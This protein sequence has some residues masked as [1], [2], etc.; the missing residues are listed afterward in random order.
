MT[1]LDKMK[2]ES[3]RIS[4]EGQS[5]QIDANT[6][7]NVLTHYSMIISETNKELGYGKDISLKINALEKGSFVIDITLVE[8]G[9]ESLFC[10]NNIHYLKD[11][12]EAIGA[13]FAIYKICK[14]KPAKESDTTININGNINIDRST[15]IN[16]YNQPIIREAISKSIETA[17]EDV[18]VTGLSVEG[19]G[20]EL[21]SFAKEDFHELIYTDFDLECILPQEKKEEVEA[22]LAIIRLSFEKG[23]K[24]QFLY[25]GF[26]I[27]MIVKDDALMQHIDNGAKFAKGDSIKVR[28]EIT[29]SY[30]E[31]YKSYENKSY[32]IK[33][34]LG[35]IEQPEQKT[36]F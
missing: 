12:V 22:V 26:K 17:N 18:N 3:M 35:H 19:C 31:A 36:L 25:N 13:I 20:H 9:L 5:H 34:F 11:F 28:M 23:S 6:L 16:I 21:V 10:S 2:R 1:N 30:N 24:W 27:Q 32:R 14:G 7:I 29:K 33:E 4:F 15:I 8:K